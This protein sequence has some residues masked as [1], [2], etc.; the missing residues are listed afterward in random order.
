MRAAK[1]DAAAGTTKFIHS[2]DG[3]EVWVGKE[4]KER[5]IVVGRRKVE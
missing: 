2:P 1:T 5:V 3:D 4:E